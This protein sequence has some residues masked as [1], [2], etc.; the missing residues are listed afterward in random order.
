MHI[1]SAPKTI[2]IIIIIIAKEGRT[3]NERMWARCP[4]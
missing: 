3:D 2:I 1:T 4:A